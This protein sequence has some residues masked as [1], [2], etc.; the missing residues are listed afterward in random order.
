MFHDFGWLWLNECLW[1]AWA[2]GW[3]ISSFFVHRTK[4][5]ETLVGRMSHVIPLLLAFIFIFHP[6]DVSV[7]YGRLYHNTTI[8][9]VGTIV[10]FFG[11][12]LAVWS[13]VHLGRYWSGMVVLKEGHRLIQTGPYRLVRHPLY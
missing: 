3:Y 1:I 12:L 8:E 9:I 7:I 2:I 4:T 11:L 5:S 13:R 6:R 10:T